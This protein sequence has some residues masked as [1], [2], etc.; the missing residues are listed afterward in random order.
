MKL[1]ISGTTCVPTNCRERSEEA[2]VVGAEM[3]REQRR[4]TGKDSAGELM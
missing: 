2:V 3:E 1:Q 4:G